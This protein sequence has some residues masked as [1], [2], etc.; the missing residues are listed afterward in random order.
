MSNSLFQCLIDWDWVWKPTLSTP[1]QSL[2][3][4][5]LTL[6]GHPKHHRLEHTTSYDGNITHQQQAAA[7]SPTPLQAQRVADALHREICSIRHFEVCNYIG[8]CLVSFFGLFLVL[9]LFLMEST[10]WSVCVQPFIRRHSVNQC[11]GGIKS[12]Q[13]QLQIRFQSRLFSGDVF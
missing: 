6:A 9:F 3:R 13:L 7:P 4:T 10:Q 1:H 2:C 8:F 11:V 5:A 12:D